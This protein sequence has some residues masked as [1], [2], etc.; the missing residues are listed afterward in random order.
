MKKCIIA[1]A[2]P[3][4][5]L[6]KIQKLMLLNQLFET[7]CIT[8]EV[9]QEV[10]SGNDTAVDCLQSAVKNC[11]IKIESV[12]N[13]SLDLKILLD[14]GEASSITLALKQKQSALLI[15][16]A[17]GRHIAQ[18]YKLS[19]I[20]VAGL[21]ILAKKHHLIDAVL[22]LLID[23]R[24]NGYWLSNNFLHEVAKLTSETFELL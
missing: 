18:Q 8:E 7:C 14:P 13:I 15:D 9:Y 5:A 24:E 1:D 6:C 19:V 17:K 4:I 16:E 10:I 2:G 12:D 20:G 22:P 21:L 3:I 11:Y 23:I